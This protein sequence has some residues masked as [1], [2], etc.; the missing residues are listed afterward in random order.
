VEPNPPRAPDRDATV[1]PTTPRP[2]RTARGTEPIE[3]ESTAHLVAGLFGDLKDLATAHGEAMR[4]EVSQELSALGTSLKLFMVALA[5]MSI[6]AL[7]LCLGVAR[8]LADALDI[9]LWWTYG[10]FA[11]VAGVASYLILRY[12]NPARRVADGN[13]DLVPEAALEDAR[14]SATFLKEQLHRVKGTKR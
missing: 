12:A 14:D 8:L 2:S 7:M 3:H 5:T 1:E 13:A 10:G 9:E 6:A 11:V 4:T